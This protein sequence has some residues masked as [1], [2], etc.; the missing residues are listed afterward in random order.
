[1]GVKI[2]EESGVFN[3]ADYGLKIGDELLVICVGGGGGGGG[4]ARGEAEYKGRGGNAGK[5]GISTGT[6]A[7]TYCSGGGGGGGY[8]GGGGGAAGVDSGGG[9][10]SGGVT[11]ATYILPALTPIAIT[12]GQGGTGGEPYSDAQNGTSTSFGTVLTALGGNGGKYTGAGGA[13]VPGGTAGGSANRGSGSSGY[14]GGGG[15]GGWYFDRPQTGGLSSIS[16]PNPSTNNCVMPLSFVNNGTGG[17][18]GSYNGIVSSNYG[19]AGGSYAVQAMDG[20]TGNGV[21]VIFW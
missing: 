3:P 7:N 2:F 13:P 19:G 14:G 18:C 12:I 21:C 1:M 6:T 17:G 20:G 11:K 15:G 10:G 4:N 8:G 5:A 16:F 9:G